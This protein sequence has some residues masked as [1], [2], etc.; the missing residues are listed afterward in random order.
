MDQQLISIVVPVHNEALNIQPLYKEIVRQL[1]RNKYKFELIFVDDGSTDDST[2][3]IER[4]VRQ[5][6]RIH[7][8]ELARNFGKEPAVTAGLNHARGDAAVILDADLQHPPRLI[9]KF[10]REWRRGADVVVGVKRYGKRE[11]WFKRK[12][13]ELFYGLFR[14]VASGVQITPHGS[15]FRLMDRKVINAFNQLSEHNRITRG[16][17]DWLGFKR[18]YVHFE[19]ELRRN[20]RP[21]YNYR[22]LIRLA[23]NTFTA[24]SLLPLKL[25]GYLG[26]AILVTATPAGILLYVEQYIMDDPLHLH[27]SG[28]AMLALLIL[29]MIGL[30]LVCLGMMALY[31]AHI[32]SEVTNRPLYVVRR[33][34]TDG[35]NARPVMSELMQPATLYRTPMV[36]QQVDQQDKKTEIHGIVAEEFTERAEPVVQEAA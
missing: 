2:R 25:A 33:Y 19:T 6:K 31:I 27:V 17:I 12:S 3:R 15:D 16:L 14:R 26:W 36:V 11:G 28:T 22:S 21:S 5:D 23:V 34:A 10:I 1:T 8:I 30:V 4:L 35:I 29:V 9:P 13:S 20:G 18:A 32:H 7:L 24:Y